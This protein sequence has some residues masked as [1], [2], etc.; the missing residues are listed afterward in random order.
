MSYYNHDRTNKIKTILQGNNLKSLIDLESNETEAF[1]NTKQEKDIRNVLDKKILDFG[2]VINQIGGKL[3]YVKSGTTG[4]TF[5]GFNPN[6]PTEPNFAVKIVAYPKRENYGDLNDIRRPENAELMM[7]KVLSYFVINN[8]TPHLVLPIGTFNTS[9]RPFLSLGKNGIVENKKYGQ[10]IKRYKKGDLHNEVSVLISEWADGGDLLE[11]IRSK[12]KTITLREW[13][14]ILFQIISALAVIQAKYPGFRHNDL[15][16][17]NIL[18][19]NI[20]SR[21]KNNKFK[22]KINNQVYILPNIGVQI[23]LWDFDFACIDGVVDNTKVNAEWTDKINVNST[24][25]RYYDI[26]YFFN[27][28][29]RKGFFPEF[30]ETPEIS[31][32][33]KDFVKR[34]VPEQYTTGPK[35]AER[36]RLLVNEEF[37]KPD[38]IL[39]ND[40][41]FERLRPKSN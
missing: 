26:H 33:V 8:Q 34:I 41:F 21:N 9:I 29:V 1:I 25:N 14:V 35:I 37:I 19:Q 24:T 23:K 3:V 28:L 20:E 30:W 27:T 16:A 18:I 15:K 32:Q 38:D 40:P 2:D 4:H 6:E 22:Y 11:Y 7:L 36:G 5:R 17:N 12:Y 10:F 13:R 39:K 31:K